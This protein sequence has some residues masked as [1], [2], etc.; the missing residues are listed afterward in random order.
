MEVLDENE[1]RDKMEQFKRSGEQ[2]MVIRRSYSRDDQRKLS[3]M[4]YEMEVYL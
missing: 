3:D 2:E 4:A 1:W